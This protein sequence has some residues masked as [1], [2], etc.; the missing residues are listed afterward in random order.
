M[1]AIDPKSGETLWSYREPHTARYQ[2]SMRK[3]YGKGVTYAEIDGR[4]VIYITSPGFF[5]TA[6]DAETGRPLAG[7]GEKVPVKGFP[8]TGVVDLLKDLG[9]PYDPYE[10]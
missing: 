10:G 1:V 3:D 7:F 4:G 5:L 6:L 8:N 9:H 2:Y